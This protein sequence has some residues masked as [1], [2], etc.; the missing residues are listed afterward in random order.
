M[1]RIR[2]FQDLHHGEE[3]LFLGNAWDVMSALA[4][5]KAGF[6][7]I[8]TTSWGVAST[9]GYTDGE[10]IGFAVHLELIRAIASQVSVP[11]SADIESGYG[12]DV[13]T[14]VDNVLRIAEAGAAGINIE[15]S[16]KSP[17]ELKL[18]GKQAALLA[19]IRAALDANGY[20]GFF[21]NAR[22]DTYLLM[23]QPLAETIARGKAYAES[24]ASGL[25]VPGLREEA[26]IVEVV[27]SI[28]LPLNVM[29]LPGVTD[30]ARLHALGVKRFSFGNAFSDAATAYVETK[31]AELA[32]LR[33][34][35]ILYGT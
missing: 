19:A 34:T 29:S 35:S 22:T 27:A 2:Q 20:G 12:A 30:A 24:G 32:R 17:R 1:S 16:A 18:V 14:V 10:R 11:V 23:K 8:G 6:Q 33:D 9:R 3:L 4:L 15:D 25:F 7:A 28:R 13:E 31:A 21:I 5:A 26:D